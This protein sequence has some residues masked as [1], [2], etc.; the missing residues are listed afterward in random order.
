MDPTPLLDIHNLFLYYSSR[1]GPVQAVDDLS[2]R[3]YPG[4]AVGVLGESGCG[5]SSV[6]KAILRLLPSNAA[7]HEGHIWMDGVDIMSLGEETFRRQVRWVKISLV[8]QAAMNALN[9]VARIGRQVE[10]A[11]LAHNL[12]TKKKAKDRILRVF[13]Q[14]DLPEDVIQCYPFQLS[15]GMRQRA[16]IAMALVAEPR[17]V[18]LD[19]PTSALD[20]LTQANIM[21]T[22]KRIKGDQNTSFIFI[23]HDVGTCSELADVVAVMYAGQLVELAEAATFFRQPLHPYSQKLMAS[24]PRLHA[25][26]ELQSIPGRPPSL[27]NPP[28]GC[29]FRDRCDQSFDKCWQNPPMLTSP[30]GSLARCWLYEAEAIQT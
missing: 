12:T 3:I 7:R 14:V 18:I 8:A 29:R 23:T 19:E 15:G 5:K 24:V 2:L 9:P 30:D 21:N 4:R 13:S 26:Q 1:E 28:P 16:V 17:L 22:L 27:I 10:E 6:S 11:L 20:L 25:E